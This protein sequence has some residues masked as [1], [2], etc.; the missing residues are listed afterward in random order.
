VDSTAG[1]HAPIA[2]AGSIGVVALGA[3]TAAAVVALSL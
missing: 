3:L 1:M 2:G